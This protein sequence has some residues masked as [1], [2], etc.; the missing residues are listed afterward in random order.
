MSKTVLNLITQKKQFGFRMFLVDPRY[1]SGYLDIP[2]N[3]VFRL[4]KIWFLYHFG[5]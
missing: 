5:Y 2:F 4:K 3:A 1:Q